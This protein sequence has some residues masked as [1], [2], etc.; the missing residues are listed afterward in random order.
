[1][2]YF[3]NEQLKIRT[4]EKG[5]I[6]Q[7]KIEFDEQGWHKD[8][9]ILSGYFEQQENGQKYIVI[10]EFNGKVA[11]YVTLLPQ[12]KNGPF[13]EKN[14]PELVDFIVFQKY[15]CNG[16]G[17]KI[18][19]VAENIASKISDTVSLGVGIHYGYGSAQRMY[20]KRGYIPDGSG[21]WY[22][23]K[24]LE[25]YAECKNDDDLV[26]FLSKSLK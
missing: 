2:I 11:G 13:A 23:N 7:L 18:L 5:D 26:I 19:D 20:V 12:A 24:R 3:E 21:A 17:S 6:E 16:I 25:Q 9:D 10:A 14:I 15:Q 4:M 1:M 22:N 8:I